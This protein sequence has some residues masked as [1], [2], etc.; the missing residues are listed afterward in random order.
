MTQHRYPQPL[1]FIDGTWREGRGGQRTAVLNPADE[2]KLAD[3]PLAEIADL[4]EAL[5]AAARAFRLWRRTTAFERA[6]ILERAAE[7]LA[8]RRAEIAFVVTC[9]QGKPLAEAGMEIDRCVDT[10]RWFAGEAT[11]LVEEVYPKRPQGFR[12]KKVAEPLGV[13]AAFTAWNFPAILIA[14]KLAPA[15]AAGCSVILKA[16][17]EAPASAMALVKALED[18]GLP[19]GLVNLVFGVPD[20]VSAHLLSQ[21]RVRKLSFTG[22]VPVG[23]LLAVRAAEHLARCTLELGGHAPAVIFEDADLEKA[24]A[25]CT[26]FKFR[27]A[28]Q[29]CITISRFYVQESVYGEVLER[30]AEKA[31]AIKTGPGLDPSSTMGPLANARRLAAMEE[32]TGDAIGCGARVVLGGTRLGNQGYFYAPTVL[33]DV[34]ETAR[35]MREEPFGPIAPFASFAD[36]E[37]VVTRSNAL[38]Y[39]LAAYAFSADPAR[40]DRMGRDLEAGM[41]GLNA[42]T[43][44]LADTPTGGL[45]AS[46]IGY[47][48]G[49]EGLEAY[50][51][52]KVLGLAS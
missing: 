16:S 24:V 28:G 42:L 8:E 20:E 33:A 6:A 47:E 35:I 39:G 45:K 9:E 32:L 37:E 50:F 41:V 11:R 21:P 7:L 4:D 51:H 2:S 19:K 14:R 36:E 27:N 44:A 52:K 26:A 31:N 43:P 49:R 1:L 13:V 3:L 30:F 12:Q 29:V 25:D 34:P 48:G 40:L 23:K 38:E 15:L 5:E 22:S 46:G 18:A 10:F 17:E